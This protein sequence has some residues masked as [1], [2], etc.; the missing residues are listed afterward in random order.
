[1]AQPPD[2]APHLNRVTLLSS[3]ALLA[4]FATIAWLAARSKSPTYDEPYHA[5]SA[6]VALHRGDFRIDSEDPPLWKYWAALPN[7]RDALRADFAGD[8]WR[9]IPS[10]LPRQWYWCVTTL[11]RTPGNDAEA[12]IARSRAMMLI[13][14]VAL[15]ALTAWWAWR[16][17]G[18]VAAITAAGLF[19]F[20]PNFLAHAPLVKN[21]VVFA[22][23]MLALLL[24]LWRCGQ[25]LTWP[26]AIAAALLCAAM[27]TVKFSGVLAGV[28]V[29]AMLGLR[30]LLPWPW[31][32]LRR[33]L[34]HRLA[35]LAA[36]VATT[37][38]CAIVSI[39][40]IWAVY[41]FRFD[42]TPEPGVRLN[43]DQLAAMAAQNQ[44]IA[45]GR[46]P[47]ASAQLGAFVRTMRLAEAHHLLPQSWLAGLLFTYQASLV[48][49]AYLFGRISPT[50]WWYYFPLAMLVKTPVATIVL[51][52]FTL[53]A[54]TALLPRLIRTRAQLWNILC[55]A[56]PFAIY[57][58]SAM[59]GHLNI[60]IRHM[61]PVY[62]LAF[63]A[64]GCAAA[65]TVRRWGRRAVIVLC[66]FGVLLVGETL[67]A[68]PDY[69]PFFNLAA[70]G[71][72]GGFHLL[73][74]S[75]LDWGQDLKALAEWQRAHPEMPLYLAYFGLADPHYYGV[76]YTPLPGGYRYD[77]TPQWPRGRCVVAVSATYLQGLLVDPELY[78]TFYRKVAALRPDDVLGGS[79]YLYE[80]PPK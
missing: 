19:A 65:W 10:N 31:M 9:S 69:I 80:F 45:A 1:M 25:R 49:P 51:A 77:P 46:S 3:F 12:F 79:L 59:R 62:P 33:E 44:A 16:L 43:T 48:R 61:L 23:S 14:G 22:L 54:M 78:D 60:G 18:A 24:V 73:G 2:A 71:E 35:R 76:N 58:I 30:A 4:S 27:L 74:D 70:G 50:G 72:R 26:R 47:Q 29:P 20:D 42:P 55:L 8:V 36:A 28:L 7:G 64:I 32:V 40:G 41:G 37:L 66:V 38:L 63:I 68:F 13:I 15:G 52:A 39:A 56:T 21:D 6:W 34:H 57:M 5:P 17:K 75:N 53:I 67:A 11:Y